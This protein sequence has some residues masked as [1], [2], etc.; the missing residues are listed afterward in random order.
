MDSDR[1]SRRTASTPL[2]GYG[3]D[4]RIELGAEDLAA[5]RALGTRFVTVYPIGGRP[6]GSPGEGRTTG[7]DYADIEDHTGALTRWFTKAGVGT[8]GVLLLRP[9]RFVF[10]I[11]AA[12]GSGPL[13]A[14]LFRQLSGSVALPARSAPTT[15]DSILPV[16]DSPD[17]HLEG[18]R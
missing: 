13:I 12:G 14:E 4:P 7:A 2:I 9:D 3:V 18:A 1:P 10:G 17:R 11:A 5:L 8:G 16:L 15:S 6:Q